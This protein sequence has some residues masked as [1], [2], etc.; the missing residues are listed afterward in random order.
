MPTTKDI[1]SALEHITDPEIPVVN[2]VEM[3]IVRDVVMV[4]E[5]TTVKMTP[6]FSGCP[7][8]ETMRQAIYTCLQNLGAT[9]V[10]VETVLHPPWSTDWIT[11]SAR[12]KLLAFGLAP[13]AI[14]GGNVNVMLFDT[15]TCPRCGST[16]VAIKNNFG[17]TLCRA[18]YVCHNC[19]EPFEQFKAL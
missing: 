9:S 10:E 2:I 1:W 17:S 5:K 18:I 13:P 6:T 15:S 11:A 3:G 4:G 14:H 7:A 16:N 8:L 12:A 19:K